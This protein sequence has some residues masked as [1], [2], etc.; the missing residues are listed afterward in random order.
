MQGILVA[1][2]ISIAVNAV[3]FLLA[4]LRKTDVVTDLSYGMSFL[5]TSLALAWIK[6]AH[7]VVGLFPF[8]AVALWSI[9]LAGY[10]F[11]R[12]LIIKVDHRF[13]GRREDPARFARFWVLQALSTALI[14]LPVIMLAEVPPSGFSML[15]LLGALIWLAG[16][17][18]ETVADE[19]KFRFKR[20][21]PEDFV[22]DG[23]WSWSRHP[24]YFGEILVWWGLWVYALPSLNGWMHIAAAGPLYITALLL[25]VS[26]I[27]PLEKEARRKYGNRSDYQAYVAR[28]SLLVP[29]P[30]RVASP[31][32][33]MSTAS[34]ASVPELSDEEFQGR[35]YELARIPLPIA[36]DW[37]RTSDVYEKAAD[38]TWKVRYEGV[39]ARRPSVQKVMRQR[40]R[41]DP[42]HPG[43]MQVSFIPG[44]WMRYRVI[45]LTED[46]S[47]MLVTSSRKRYLWIMSR[48]AEI[49]EETYQELVAKAASFG[50]DTRL[51]ERVPQ[52]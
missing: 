13:D 44:V 32:A 25:F 34:L 4:S 18:I 6:G 22:M 23:L 24:N 12:I 51:L 48:Q 43:E 8:I 38:G 36:R 47:A 10:L 5:L 45:H 33:R 41:R 14:M 17:L 11:R 30:P 37:I 50:F 46:R 31:S 40:L 20:A 15:H 28:T 1:L 27:P 16:F 35:W 3:F 19:Q 49:P 7:G 2:V 29:L 9:R 26:G 52:H 42:A 21:H 39:P